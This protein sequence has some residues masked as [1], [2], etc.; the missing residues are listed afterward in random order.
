M[1]LSKP[2]KLPLYEIPKLLKLSKCPQNLK[3][4]MSITMC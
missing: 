2:L 1:L 4:A 3:A